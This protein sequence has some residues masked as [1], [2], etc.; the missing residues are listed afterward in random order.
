MSETFR[1]G[2]GW[3][4]HR[5]VANRPLFLGGVE[6]P[7]ARG[8]AGHSDADVLVH[9]IID[10]LLGAAADGDIGAHFPDDD[11]A[12]KNAHSLVLMSAVKKRVAQA[13]WRIGN[14]D[15]TIVAQE[16]RLAP[17]RQAMR[18]AIAAML[19]IEVECVSVKAKTPEGLGAE[20]VGEAISAQAVVLLRRAS[21]S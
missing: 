10:A 4:I 15:A 17:F 5:L 19:E 6:I 3:D 16:P 9:A 14:V 21:T 20:G 11:P 12:W 1:I 18:A 2:Q 8:L 7:H 13:G